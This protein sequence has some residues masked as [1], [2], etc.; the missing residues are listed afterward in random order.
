MAFSSRRRIQG[1]A[2]FAELLDSTGRI[3]IYFNRD[4]ICPG[5]NKSLYNEVYK[6]LLDIG[7]IIGIEGKLFTTKVGQQTVKV[8]NF[9]ILNKSLRPL[10]IPK[11][12]SEGN[13]YDAFNDPELRF[14]Q[15]YVDLIVNPQVRE[16][17]FK[18]SKITT[19]IRDFLTERGYLEV[20]TPIL[21]PIPGGAAARPINTH[22]NAH[23]TK[24]Y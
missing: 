12:D 17:F 20:E 15:R 23:T 9:T 22:H 3:Q 21:Q 5:E 4:E 7:D 24:L 6:K 14:R 1:S 2:S 16:T 18:R 19:T 10:P 11:I 13:I 8:S